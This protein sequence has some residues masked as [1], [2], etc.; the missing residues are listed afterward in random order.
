MAEKQAKKRGEK[1]YSSEDL[2]RAMFT[3]GEGMGFD[4]L[5]TLGVDEQRFADTAQT[6]Q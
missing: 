6:P 1:N 2:V 3:L 4:L 5:R